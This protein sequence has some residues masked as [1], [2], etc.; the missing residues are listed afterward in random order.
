[1]S[2]RTLVVDDS[3][4]MQALIS[5]TLSADPGIQ[6]LDPARREE[7]MRAIER[8]RN[9]RTVPIL[10]VTHDVREA[11]RLGDRVIALG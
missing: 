6:V 10:M 4:T 8:V 7:A 9:A 3:L 1:M 11:E 5:R 2:V